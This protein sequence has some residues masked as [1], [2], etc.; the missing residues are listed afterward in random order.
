MQARRVVI[1]TEET[2]EANCADRSVGRKN[3]SGY[4]YT[5][6]SKQPVGDDE[7]PGGLFKDKS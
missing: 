7:V 4:I 5:A 1:V 2:K 6:K 3:G